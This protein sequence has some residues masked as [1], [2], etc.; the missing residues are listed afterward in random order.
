MD[1]KVSNL[2]TRPGQGGYFCWTF[3]NLGGGNSN[4]FY[5]H[6]DTWGNDPIW[7]AHI[8]QMGLVIHQLE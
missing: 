2:K 1:V 7:L 6:P 4:I 8:F 3:K 5:F